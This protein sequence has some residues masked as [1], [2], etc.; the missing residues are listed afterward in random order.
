MA[1]GQLSDSRVPTDA[2]RGAAPLEFLIRSTN[3]LP[4]PR[5]NSVNSRSYCFTDTRVTL[6]NRAIPQREGRKTLRSYLPCGAH[7]ASELQGGSAMRRGSLNSS[8]S[9]IL[10]ARFA[11]HLPTPGFDLLPRCSHKLVISIWHSPDNEIQEL[12]RSE[13]IEGLHFQTEP[14]NHSLQ[15]N[16]T[17]NDNKSSVII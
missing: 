8:V 16:M 3:N 6:N 15:R 14:C 13:Y 17:K 10:I 2:I 11:P 9:R 4:Q 12:H 1:T 5:Y 7:G